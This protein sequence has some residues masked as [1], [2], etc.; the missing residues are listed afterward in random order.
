[1]H[2][3]L[4]VLPHEAPDLV[5]VLTSSRLPRDR[6]GTGGQQKLTVFMFLRTPCP[7]PYALCRSLSCNS[8]SC[9]HRATRSRRQLAGSIVRSSDCEGGHELLNIP[10]AKRAVYLGFLV[11][12]QFVKGV[13]TVF[14]VIFKDWHYIPPSLLGFNVNI[15]PQ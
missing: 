8:A 7:V 4:G 1:L 10:L 6:I 14:A 15:I 12:H 11:H 2:S 3:E 5:P 9:A 13:F